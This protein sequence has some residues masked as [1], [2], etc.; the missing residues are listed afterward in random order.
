MPLSADMGDLHIP[1]VTPAATPE[2]ERLRAVADDVALRPRSLFDFPEDAA[3]PGGAPASTPGSKMAPAATPGA[4]RTPGAGVDP[5]EGANPGDDL[6]DLLEGPTPGVVGPDV[7]MDVEMED[8]G[9]GERG[10]GGEGPL[11]D[12]EVGPEGATTG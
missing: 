5:A 9:V 7:G 10:V 8:A 6:A 4:G 2:V 3:T 1:G 12:G 11:E